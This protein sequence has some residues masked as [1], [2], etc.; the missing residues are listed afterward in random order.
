MRPNHALIRKQLDAAKEADRRWFSLNRD[1]MFRLRPAS[2]A[3]SQVFHVLTMGSFPLTQPGH[4]AMMIASRKANGA[5]PVMLPKGAPVP[6]DTDEDLE[7][8]FGSLPSRPDCGDHDVEGVQGVPRQGSYGS[9]V[10][11]ERTPKTKR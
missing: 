9:W 4:A 2:F 11:C 6:R 8:L 3:E 5:C 10:R 7:R 1:R